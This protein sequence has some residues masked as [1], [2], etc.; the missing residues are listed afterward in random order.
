MV[1]D[2]RYEYGTLDEDGNR[3]LL[4]GNET[5]DEEYAWDGYIRMLQDIR[6]NPG[7]AQY[8]ALVKNTKHGIDVLAIAYI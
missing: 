2:Y 8:V 7:S 4:Y 6:A 1:M 5:N 3:H